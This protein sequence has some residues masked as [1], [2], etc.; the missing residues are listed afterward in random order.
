MHVD[1]KPEG[2]AVD[3]ANGTLLT[4]L[5]DAD[6]TVVVDVA[7]HAVK[8][9]WPAACGGDG[10][11]GV[12]TDSARDLVF[13]AC[14]DHVQVLDGAHDGAHDGAPLG[15]LDVGAGIDDVQW[16][17]GEHLLYVAAVRVAKMVIVRSS[18]RGDLTAIAT[19]ATSEGARNAVI[20]G[21]GNAYL[22]DGPHAQLLVV[23][24][25]AP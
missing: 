4:N 14:S 16:L 3:A 5:E 17:E 9:V 2:H 7:P 19:V 11:R 15:R 8:H 24:R 21:A 6:K 1:G 20:D 12:A 18:D 13:V 25:R 10:P 22:A 23:A